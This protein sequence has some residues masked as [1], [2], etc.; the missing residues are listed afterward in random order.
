MS[1][2]IE[3]AKKIGNKKLNGVNSVYE[4]ST[5]SIVTQTLLNKKQALNNVECYNALKAQYSKL[6]QKN[7][8]TALR[9]LYTSK[10]I[11]RTV[12]TKANKHYIFYYCEQVLQNK[13]S[14]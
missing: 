7:V 8:S 1:I 4:H 9:N 11:K 10:H 13:E 6:T 5:R 14:K 12:V 2:T 3:Q